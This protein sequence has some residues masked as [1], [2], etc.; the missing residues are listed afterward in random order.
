MSFSLRFRSESSPTPD[1]PPTPNNQDSDSDSALENE[2]SEMRAPFDL[3]AAPPQLFC[4]DAPDQDEVLQRLYRSHS[5]ELEAAYRQLTPIEVN[6]S[7]LKTIHERNDKVMALTFLRKRINLVLDAIHTIPS[8]SP[9]LSWN[10]DTSFLDCLACTSDNIGLD[11]FVPNVAHNYE[12]HLTLDRPYQQFHKKII[13]LGFNPTRSMLWLGKS[14]GHEDA[15]L[16]MVPTTYLDRHTDGTTNE[17]DGTTSLS[18][19]HYRMVVLMMAYFLKQAGIPSIIVRNQYP[20][21]DDNDCIR[22][23]TNIL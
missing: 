18:P 23:S 5:E 17:R 21:L 20:D 14:H 3:S 13:Y 2:V 15:W 12:F 1:N 19:R 16:A 7:R 9:N 8:H 11:A 10:A 22:A 6:L 4:V